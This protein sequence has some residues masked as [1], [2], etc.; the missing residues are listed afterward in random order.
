[1]LW[2]SEKDMN[3]RDGVYLQLNL[4]GAIRVSGVGMPSWDAMATGLSL[5]EDWTNRMVEQ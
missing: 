2:M 5:K 1:M 3:R 4:D